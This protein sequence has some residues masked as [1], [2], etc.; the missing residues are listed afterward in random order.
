MKIKCKTKYQEKYGKF[1]QKEIKEKVVEEVVD[2][3]NWRV[4]PT[5]QEKYRKLLKIV[6]AIHERMGGFRNYTEQTDGM[7]VD[8][9]IFY[10]VYS[11]KQSGSFPDHVHN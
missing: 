1:S 5:L 11:L 2:S 6:S 8:T 3:H 9:N 4:G 10:G 7:T